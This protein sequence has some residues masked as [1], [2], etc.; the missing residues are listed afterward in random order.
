M[1][2]FEYLESTWPARAVYAWD[3]GF[4]ALEIAHLCGLTVVFG[5]M[6]IVDGRLLGL[7]RDIPVS[8]LERHVLPYVWGGFILAAL[9]GGWLFLYEAQKLA[10]DPAFVLKMCLLPL[11]GLNALF[12]H[13]VAMRRLTDWDRGRPP[14][15]VQLSALVSLVLWT[16]IL[17]C[18][19][20]IAYYYPYGF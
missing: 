14:L 11:A 15:M 4:P 5:G 13:K 10:D 7:R 6:V 8:V 2:V 20:L 18:G 9:S 16:L 3:W 17:A 1:N 12:M 19:R